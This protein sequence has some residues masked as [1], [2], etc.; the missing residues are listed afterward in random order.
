MIRI[1]DEVIYED[2]RGQLLNVV[3]LRVSDEPRQDGVF[4]GQVR[5]GSYDGHTFIGSIDRIVEVKEPI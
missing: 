1:D 2:V 5:G 4:T 3:V